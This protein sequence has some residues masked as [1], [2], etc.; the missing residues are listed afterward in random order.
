MKKLLLLSILLAGFTSQAQTYLPFPTSDAHWLV[1]FWIGPGYPYEYHYYYMNAL[2]NDTT[3]NSFT[4]GKVYRVDVGPVTT[5]SGALRAN[6]SSQV[7]FVPK[8][9]LNE[10]LLFDYGKNVGDTIAYAYT[11]CG[12]PVQNEIVQFKDSVLLGNRYQR[13]LQLSGSAIW[14][15]GVGGRGGLLENYNVGVSGADELIC[16]DAN[17]T[18]WWDNGFTAGQCSLILQNVSEEILENKMS[19]YPNPA[20]DQFTVNLTGQ[21]KIYDVMGRLIKEKEVIKDQSIDCKEFAA[22]VYFVRVGEGAKMYVEKL[23]I[24]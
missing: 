22:G 6:D 16:M 23:V 4:Y 19:F 15:E 5:Y 12:F 3:I 1:R 17:D 24:Q 9:S 20:H 13:R 18:M 2:N 14:I 21:L 8:D 11:C 10:L 7:Y